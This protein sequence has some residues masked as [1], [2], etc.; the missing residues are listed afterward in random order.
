MEGIQHFILTRFNVRIFTQDKNGKAVRTA[1]WLKH[2]FEVFERYCLPSIAGQTCKDFEWI[3]LFDS[4]TPGE[5]KERISGYQAVCPQFVPVFVEPDKGKYFRQ[6]FRA[7]VVDRIKADRVL[8]TYLDND[9][10]LS[11][12]FVED[13]RKRASNLLDGTFIFYTSG[14]Q[15]FKEFGLMLRVHYRRNHFVSVIEAGL[16]ATLKTI[17][18]YGS[19]YYIDRIPGAQIEY[20]EDCPLWCEMIHERN[21]GNDAHFLLGIKPVRD[22][23]TLRREFGVDEDNKYSV[24]LLAFRFAPRYLKT[25]IWRVK[26]RL[27]GRKW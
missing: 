5:Y 4:E 9:D 12:S 10:A 15:Y 23:Q 17:Y 14:F 19:H 3:V 7:A 18:G 26:C 11:L 22:S 8:T 1:E 24:S 21:M 16:P 13:I 6:F 25:F 2:R 20:I 27:F